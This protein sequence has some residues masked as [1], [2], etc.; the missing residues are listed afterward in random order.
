[1][2]KFDQEIR[3]KNLIKKFDQ[4]IRS[5]NLINKFDQQNSWDRNGAVDESAIEIRPRQEQDCNL[6]QNPIEVRPRQERNKPWTGVRT[7]VGLVSIGN[8]NQNLK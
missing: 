4:E 3:S 7:N 5:S 8:S 6:E 1:M 2:K